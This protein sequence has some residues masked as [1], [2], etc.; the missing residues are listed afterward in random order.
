MFKGKKIRLSGTLHEGMVQLAMG[1]H[2]L[3]LGMSMQDKMLLMQAQDNGAVLDEE[4]LLFLTGEQTNNFDVDVDDH[5]V[6]DLALNDNNIFQEDKCD[7]FD[8]DEAE[9]AIGVH[10]AFYLKQAQR[11][12]LAL[13]DGSEL[14]KTHHV[15]VLVPS[16]EDDLELAETT[17]IKMNEKMNDQVRAMKTVFE[18]LEAE[19]DQNAID[20]KSDEIERKNILI[21]N[22]NLITNYI[23]QYVFF[24][25]TDSAMTTSRFHE[26][27]TAYAVVMNLAVKLEAENSKLL[28]K[29]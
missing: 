5:P 21:T 14:L 9:T 16:S 23:A 3:E 20:L 8:S 15:P 26:L 17:R 1:E 7:A 28:E 22:E 11:A 4:E 13:Y 25:V 18:N 6:K 10:N 12:Q 19:V 24:I 29:N 27:S 2:K